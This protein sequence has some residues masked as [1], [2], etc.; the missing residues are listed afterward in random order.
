MQMSS[1]LGAGFY[2][3]FENENPSVRFPTWADVKNYSKDTIELDEWVADRD[4]YTVTQKLKTFPWEN[5]AVL[6]VEG[7]NFTSPNDS[8]V[9]FNV[10]V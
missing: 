8:K 9:N 4:R 6:L 3:C 10:L 2:R 1:C 7:G 5:T